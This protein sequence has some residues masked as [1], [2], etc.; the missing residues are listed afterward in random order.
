MHML[1]GWHVET[2]E[3]GGPIPWSSAV[4][5]QMVGG[6]II[7][8]IHIATHSGIPW[9]LSD[10]VAQRWEG[11]WMGWYYVNIITW[12]IPSHACSH[13]EIE[14]RLPPW[15]PPLQ[16]LVRETGY[17]CNFMQWCPYL[18]AP[19]LSHLLSYLSF[20]Y[21]PLIHV[22]PCCLIYRKQLPISAPIYWWQRFLSVPPLMYARPVQLPQWVMARGG[23]SAATPSTA[24]FFIAWCHQ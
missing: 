17:C 10:P 14:K 16:R 1:T 18:G 2:L 5:W 12:T 21:P 8:L 3:V 15:V 7:F 9:S 20:H 22:P 13:A 4:L 6:L 19:L 24:S 11:L 23:L